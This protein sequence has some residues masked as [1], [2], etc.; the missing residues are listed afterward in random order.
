MRRML[1]LWLCLI[2]LLPI[3]PAVAEND[4]QR[5]VIAVTSEEDAYNL[6]I[7]EA[8]FQENPNITIEYRL[9]SEE[10]LNS[11]LMT[12]QADFDIVILNYQT[13]LGMAERDYL[14]TLDQIG[15]ETYPEELLDVS[16]LLTY[17]EKLFALPISINQE[18]W[19]IHYELSEQSNIEYPAKDGVWTWSEYLEFSKQFPISFGENKEKHL[20]MMVGASLYDFP[21]LQNVQVDMLLNYLALYPNEIDRFFTDYFPTFRQVLKSDALMPMELSESSLLREERTNDV[22]VTQTSSDNLICVTQSCREREDWLATLELLR[23]PN[24]TTED[25]TEEEVLGILPTLNSWMLLPVP[26][27]EKTMCAIL[28]QCVLAAS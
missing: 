13:L 25:I 21:S 11:I 3:F 7:E 20:Y 5:L 17:N 10:Q 27:F 15:L 19:F 8:F 23:D 28:A 12:N 24:L 26:V 6:P 2:I 14:L 1:L 22:L 18:A 16:G 4:T 9:Y